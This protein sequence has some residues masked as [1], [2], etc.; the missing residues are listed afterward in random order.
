MCVGLCL[1]L[2]PSTAGPRQ[3]QLVF[4]YIRL[5]ELTR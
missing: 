3:P 5:F 4:K 1:S 2:Q